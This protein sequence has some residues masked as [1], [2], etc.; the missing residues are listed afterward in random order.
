M[1]KLFCITVLL[2]GITA[3]AAGAQTTAADSLVRIAQGDAK[4]FRLNAA[5][6][7][8]FRKNRG[9]SGSDYFKPVPANVSNSALLNDSVYVMAYRQAAYAKTHHRHSAGHYILWGGVGLTVVVLAAS[10]A[11]YNSVLTGWN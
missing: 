10:A 6:F 2:A 5:D 1:I 7:K 4:N 3:L 8:K 11:A 9:N